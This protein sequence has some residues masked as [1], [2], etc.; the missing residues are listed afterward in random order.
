MQFVQVLISPLHSSMTC[1]LDMGCG[2]S[3]QMWCAAGLC[4]NVSP[5][6]AIW[7]ESERLCH[8][9]M[10]LQAVTTG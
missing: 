5:C 6:L 10:S 7:K 1:T 4:F 8:Q 9:P 2:A 3:A